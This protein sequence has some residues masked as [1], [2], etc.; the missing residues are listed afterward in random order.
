M[1]LLYCGKVEFIWNYQEKAETSGPL[2]SRPGILSRG[3]KSPSGSFELSS[4]H[5]HF[6]CSLGSVT[7]GR[8]SPWQWTLALMSDS[9]IMQ[10]I[11]AHGESF[12]VPLLCCTAEIRLLKISLERTAVSKHLS[13]PSFYPVTIMFQ[14]KK[15]QPKTAFIYSIVQYRENKYV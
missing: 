3:N 10:H 7:F 1:P 2:T 4:F 12:R 15:D 5:F 11:S 6:Y 9:D 14:N 13:Q 8:V